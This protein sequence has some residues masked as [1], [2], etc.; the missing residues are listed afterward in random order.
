M[1]IK[2]TEW[3]SNEI[4]SNLSQENVAETGQQPPEQMLQ[5]HIKQFLQGNS[6]KNLSSVLLPEIKDICFSIDPCAN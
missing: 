1:D 3:K 2:G 4:V 5:K 6:Q